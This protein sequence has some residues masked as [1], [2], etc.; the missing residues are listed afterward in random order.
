MKIIIINLYLAFSFIL[1]QSNATTNNLEETEAKKPVRSTL[2]GVPSALVSTDS[3]KNNSQNSQEL[4]LDR[5]VMKITTHDQLNHIEG[6]RVDYLKESQVYL[7][8]VL[9]GRDPNEVYPVGDEAL[10]KYKI[11]HSVLKNPS[12]ISIRVCNSAILRGLVTGF[13][14][15]MCSL[16][17]K[18]PKDPRHLKPSDDHVILE[19]FVNLRRLTLH[20]CY[21]R[22]LDFLS[23]MPQVHYLGFENLR[24]DILS[25]KQFTQVKRIYFKHFPAQEKCLNVPDGFLSLFPN[26]TSIDVLMFGCG[27]KISNRDISGR[28]SLEKLYLDGLEHIDDQAFQGLSSLKELTL[29]N[30]KNVKGDFRFPALKKLISIDT[31]GTSI[32]APHSAKE[33]KHRQEPPVVYLGVSLKLEEI[34]LKVS[35]CYLPSKPIIGSTMYH[36]K[37]LTLEGVSVPKD[38]CRRC[39]SLCVFDF[40]PACCK[41]EALEIPCGLRELFLSGARLQVRDRPRE[42]DIFNVIT[43]LRHLEFLGLSDL[44]ITDKYQGELIKL[45]GY[46]LQNCKKA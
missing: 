11:F 27:A 32:K 33:A 1:T 17:I 38:L 5:A 20:N 39:I 2:T 37:H 28:A 13:Y 29:Y 24:I 4:I 44:E 6:Y 8:S 30:V 46:S 9:I 35:S 26:C 42:D 22:N 31:L 10:K 43:T 15:K 23:H 3:S 41:R 7:K 16:S 21:L 34:N 12:I 40:T 25:S 45:K 14:T 18:Y 36:L 19:R